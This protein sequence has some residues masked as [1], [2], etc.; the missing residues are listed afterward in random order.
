MLISFSG[1]NRDIQNAYRALLYL[2]CERASRGSRSFGAA[3]L[4]RRTECG[5]LDA[6]LKRAQGDSANV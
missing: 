5:L 6:I 2:I 4:R 3:N 1:Y